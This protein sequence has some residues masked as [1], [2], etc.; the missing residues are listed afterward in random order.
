MKK[1]YLTAILNGH[2]ELQAHLIKTKRILEADLQFQKNN[3]TKY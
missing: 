1:D 2:T 3:I